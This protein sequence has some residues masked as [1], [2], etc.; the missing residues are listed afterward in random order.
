MGRALDRPHFVTM[1]RATTGGT[2]MMSLEAPGILQ[3]R[4]ISSIEHAAYSESRVLAFPSALGQQAISSWGE[5][6][7]CHA[8]VRTMTNSVDQRVWHQAT[9]DSGRLRGR[10]VQPSTDHILRLAPIICPGQS[11]PAVRVDDVY[12]ARG[13]QRSLKTRGQVEPA[14]TAAMTQTD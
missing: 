2:H 6:R 5:N 10:R 3:P 7:V 14:G 12:G 9:D 11:E 8:Q 1:F 13:E 4:V